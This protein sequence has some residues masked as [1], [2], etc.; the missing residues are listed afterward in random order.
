M[1]VNI[2][3]PGVIE[4]R[5]CGGPPAGDLSQKLGATPRSRLPGNKASDIDSQTCPSRACLRLRAPRQSPVFED[6][7]LHEPQ[8]WFFTTVWLDRLQ[9]LCS[10]S[11]ISRSRPCTAIQASAFAIQASTFAIQV[12][13]VEATRPC[14]RPAQCPSIPMN[15]ATLRL[16]KVAVCAHTSAQGRIPRAL[17]H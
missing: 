15:H 8:I 13:H 16:S 3:M 5:G 6:L 10:L 7:L 9:H 17:Q 14:D 11:T 12:T 2:S 4:D 1:G